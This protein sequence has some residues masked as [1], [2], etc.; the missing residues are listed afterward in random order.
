[1]A[2]Q[3]IQV[4]CKHCGSTD[5]VKAGFQAGKQRYLCH[6]CKRKFK[7]D[8]MPFHMKVEAGNISSAL[9]MYYTGS[10][11]TDIR[12]HLKQ[13]TGYY[14]S[15]SRVFYWIE[16][17]TNTAAN[18]F[19]KVK[20]KVGD[21]WIADET[22]IDLDKGVKV[23]FWD[24]ID[25]DTRFLLASRVSLTRTTEDAKRLVQDA[26][27]RAGK[28]PKVILTDK[29]KSYPDGIFTA[30]GGYTEH[31][32]GSPFKVASRGKHKPSRTLP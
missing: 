15:K 30:L 18:Y 10:S 24:I 21:T 9:A 19:G 16:K 7:A 27:K 13:E 6:V 12:N 22:M 28:P 23:W 17:Y 8:D 31:V 20:P 26:V 1:M 2:E 11:I 29:M 32:Q 14:P 4:T 5:V 25:A 3:A